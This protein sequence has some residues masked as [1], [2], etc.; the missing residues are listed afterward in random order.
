MTKNRA[1]S[2]SFFRGGEECEL[3]DERDF[4]AGFLSRR[5]QDAIL[6]VENSK[7]DNFPA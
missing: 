6:A 5:V 7:P 4:A 1:G 2:I 3:T